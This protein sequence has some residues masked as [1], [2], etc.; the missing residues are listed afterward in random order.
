MVAD[1]L[2]PVLIMHRSRLK[3][4]YYLLNDNSLQNSFQ[5]SQHSQAL[6]VIHLL[7]KGICHLEMQ[8]LGSDKWHPDTII[9]VL[10]VL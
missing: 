4:C 2:K 6:M 10:D 7:L 1:E 3:K 5:G 9:Q 8:V